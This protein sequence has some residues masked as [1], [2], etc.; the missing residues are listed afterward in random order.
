MRQANKFEPVSATLY[1]GWNSS[2]TGYLYC[3]AMLRMYVL[4]Y[5]LGRL[6]F[7]RRHRQIGNALRNSFI[8]YDVSDRC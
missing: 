5:V 1:A 6:Y 7:E 3:D 4:Y 2:F 8:S